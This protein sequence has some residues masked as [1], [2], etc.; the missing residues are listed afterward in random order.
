MNTPTRTIPRLSADDVAAINAVRDLLGDYRSNLRDA[1][2]FG[3]EV[4]TD[5]GFTVDAY[6][7]G[8]VEY[9]AE[10][11]CDA[12]FQILNVSNAYLRAAY[13]DEQLHRP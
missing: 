10:I 8:R 6:D 2:L 5:D 1:A 7:Y 3:G 9:A 12:L 13:T 11:A 4:T